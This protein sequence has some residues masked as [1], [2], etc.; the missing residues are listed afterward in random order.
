M[1]A[2]RKRNRW[3]MLSMFRLTK[4]SPRS[5][6]TIVQRQDEVLGRCTSQLHPFPAVQAVTDVLQAGGPVVDGPGKADR[7]RPDLLTGV[8]I[9]DDHHRCLGVDQYADPLFR[10]VAGA[11]EG[12]DGDV[13]P[14]VGKSG[15][16]FLKAVRQPGP[17][18]VVQAVLVPGH[19]GRVVARR[20]CHVHAR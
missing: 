12:P 5:P 17:G 11:V 13:V 15:E 20:P 1:S 6:I 2:G 18:A 10:T 7:G 14:S 16:L 8:G 19:G 4:K 3:T 9:G